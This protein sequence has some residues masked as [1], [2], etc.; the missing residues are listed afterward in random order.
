MLPNIRVHVKKNSQA[1]VI[2]HRV[3]NRAYASRVRSVILQ[4]KGEPHGLSNAI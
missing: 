3:E 2:C 1:K 4:M